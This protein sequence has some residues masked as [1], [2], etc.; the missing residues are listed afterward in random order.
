MTIFNFKDDDALGTVSS[1]D[2]ATVIVAVEDNEQ[3]KRLQVNRLAV[4]QSSK[5]G[6]HLIGLISQVTR[7]RLAESHDKSSEDEPSEQNLCKVALIG[8]L[9]DADGVRRNVFRRTLESVPEIDANCFSLEGEYL[10]WRIQLR[11]A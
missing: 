8:S 6:Q 9:L 1:V 4:L 11:S 10:T 2:T 5:P 3:L 7:K